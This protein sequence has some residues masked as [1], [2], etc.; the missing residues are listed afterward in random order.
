MPDYRHVGLETKDRAAATAVGPVVG[1][2]HKVTNRPSFE[3]GGGA[4]TLSRRVNVTE[5]EQRCRR[6]RE[7]G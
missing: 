3:D 2:N 1:L 7:G 6:D 5:H 4:T